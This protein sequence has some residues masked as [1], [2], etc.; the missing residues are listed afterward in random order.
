MDTDL[1]KR[2]LCVSGPVRLAQYLPTFRFFF[3]FFSFS[4]FR[5]TPLILYLQIEKK[6]AECVG[7]GVGVGEVGWVMLTSRAGEQ[8][9]TWWPSQRA[10]HQHHQQQQLQWRWRRNAVVAL[11]GQFVTLSC[12]SLR[13]SQNKWTISKILSL[14]SSPRGLTDFLYLYVNSLTH[15]SYLPLEFCSIYV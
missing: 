14:V 6:R 7:V 9:K 13:F 15:S 8:T 11:V 3:F 1:L 4:F 2:P 5:S 12:R 10:S